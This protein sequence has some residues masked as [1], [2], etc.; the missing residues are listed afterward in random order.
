M[1]TGSFKASG[2][3]F[4]KNRLLVGDIIQRYDLKPLWQKQVR[5]KHVKKLLKTLKTLAR[6][7]GLEFVCGRGHRKEQLQRDI[8][9]LE[10]A[11]EKIREY[12][13]KIHKCGMRNSYSKTDNDATF[14]HMKDDHMMNGQLKPAFNVQH[15]VNSGFIVSVGIFPDPTD[16]LTLKPFV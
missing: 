1:E 9:D 3:I 12:E 15:A 6:K 2:K 4:K 11:L 7:Q 10:A 16:V 13:L 8:E 5:K 14:M